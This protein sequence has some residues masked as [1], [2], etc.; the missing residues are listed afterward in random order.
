MNLC[1][2][3]KLYIYIC[4]LFITRHVFYHHMLLKW[5]IVMV[6]LTITYCRIVSV[7]MCAWVSVLNIAA[8]KTCYNII[9]MGC[10]SYVHICTWFPLR[11]QH[12]NMAMGQHLRPEPATTLCMFTM[13]SMGTK[14]GSMGK[15]WWPTSV[16]WSQT[17]L[18]GF[19]PEI[20]HGESC[21]NMFQ[22]PS[23]LSSI[24][25]AMLDFRSRYLDIVG[26][27]SSSQ[28][29]PADMSSNL[30]RLHC[31]TTQE[32]QVVSPGILRIRYLGMD[33]E[34]THWIP[35]K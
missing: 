10:I 18:T 5:P 20:Y 21:P 31:G 13:D 29:F 24:L 25:P 23:L 4:L 7:Q 27:V 17:C 26:C 3:K 28:M 8:T 22:V 6:I 16:C 35:L 30:L 1:I 32:Y 2:W 33:E 15:C 19:Y 9:C 34:N 14:W 12:W 11:A